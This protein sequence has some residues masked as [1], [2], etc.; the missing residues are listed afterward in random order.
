[1]GWTRESGLGFGKV[2]RAGV[3]WVGVY[4]VFF[5]FKKIINREIMVDRH[6]FKIF[7]N[8]VNIDRSTFKFF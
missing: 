5:C 4:L 8:M 6:N 3:M 1:M 2:G 7:V